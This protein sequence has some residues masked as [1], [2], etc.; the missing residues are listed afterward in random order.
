M[1][2]K[3]LGKW[4]IVPELVLLP[5]GTGEESSENGGFDLR[6]PSN[7]KPGCLGVVSKIRGKGLKGSPKNARY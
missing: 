4:E 7:T 5:E 6:L 2:G 3:W 1:V